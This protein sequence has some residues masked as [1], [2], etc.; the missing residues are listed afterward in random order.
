M[1]NACA[2]PA[3]SVHAYSPPLTAMRRYELT[4]AGLVHTSTEHAEL[5]W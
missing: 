5:N 3:V 4:A 1:V 2:A